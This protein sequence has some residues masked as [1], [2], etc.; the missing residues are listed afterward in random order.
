[1]YITE[2]IR[3]KVTKILGN[4][5]LNL[6]VEEV[7]MGIF[8]TGVKLNTGHTGIAFTPI[9]E[10]PE[11]VCCPSSLTRLPEAGKLKGK[12]VMEMLKLSTDKNVLKSAIGVATLN[13]LTGF[14]IKTG[15]SLDFEIENTD[16]G[17]D[18]KILNSKNVVIVGVL[19]PYIKKFKNTDVNLSIIENSSAVLKRDELQY[20]IPFDKAGSVLSK[21][22]AVIITG[23]TIVNHTIE[24]I[25][26]RIKPDSYIV[27]TGPTASMYPILNYSHYSYSSSARQIQ[28]VSVNNSPYGRPFCKE[29]AGCMSNAG[30]N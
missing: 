27:I 18:I 22:D 4:R 3:N 5:I 29:G 21:A 24:D 15:S 19:I 25:L 8:Y 2:E 26:K 30:Y 11:A 17:N 14:L 20:Y 9:R 7:V 6:K 13:A 23:A 16:A 28:S 1:M 10:V 12:K